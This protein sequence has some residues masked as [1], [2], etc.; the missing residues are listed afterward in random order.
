[1]IGEVNVRKLSKILYQWVTG[2]LWNCYQLLCVTEPSNKGILMLFLPH[3]HQRH[4][5]LSG[6]LSDPFVAVE[7]LEVNFPDAGIGDEFEAGQTGRS[8]D[9]DLRFVDPHAV[10]RR[11]GDGVRFRVDGSHAMVVLN[12]VS[13]FVA[14][15][16]AAQTAVVSGGEDR[17][18]A[19]NY[20]ADILPA[21]GAPRCHLFRDVHKIFVPRYTV[22]VHTFLYLMYCMDLT[23]V[24]PP[25]VIR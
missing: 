11:L 12:I 3:E 16:C 24:R 23:A 4:T 22:I 9:I 10:L 15:R 5:A 1:M 6:I 7:F 21:A 18:V 20:S 19:D 13:E 14:M 25:A 17:L 2:V 8:G